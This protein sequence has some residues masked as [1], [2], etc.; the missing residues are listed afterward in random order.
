M[1][2]GSTLLAALALGTAALT[3][4]ATTAPTLTLAQQAKKADVIVR[5]KLGTSSTVKEGEVSWLVYPLTITET[6]A[7]DAASLPQRDGQPVLYLLSGVEGLP[8]LR[9]GQEA[10]LLLY[11]QRLDS[12]IVGFNQGL[13]PVENGKVT[14][15]GETAGTSTGTATG[16]TASP[17]LPNSTTPPTPATPTP[18][19]STPGTATPV[20]TTGPTAPTPAP[21]TSAATATT[22]PATATS[23]APAPTPDN[24]LTDPAKFRDVLRAAREAK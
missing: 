6:I 12:P 24:P 18:G 2:R 9:T 5:A 17:A 15:L 3:A 1:R 23:P 10:F 19:S 8:Q 13:Y 4:Q 11:S 21:G 22:T 20:P 16:A 7:G 14:R